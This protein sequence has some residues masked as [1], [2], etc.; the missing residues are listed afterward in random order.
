MK[1]PGIIDGVFLAAVIGLGAVAVSL[2]L[3]GLVGY[4]SLFNLVLLA[5]TLSY[6]LFLLKRSDTRIGRIVLLTAWT[7]ISLACWFFGLM[8][9]EQVLI[10]AGFIW[11]TRSLYYH[12]SLF[13]ALLDLGLVSAGVAAGAWA[14]VNTGSIG[15]A[16]WFFFLIQ[17]LFC[18]I[19]ELARKQAGEDFPSPARA[20]FQSAQRVAAEA[21]RKLSQH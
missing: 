5:A 21:V 14:I 7:M 6:L 20:S 2:V 13:S 17:A 15:A 9:L 16:L 10:Q 19:P 18:L 12:D 8:L 4:G 11:L 3:G 1:K